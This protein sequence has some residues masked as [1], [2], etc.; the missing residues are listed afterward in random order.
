MKVPKDSDLT[1]KS[2][3]RNIRALDSQPHT[4]VL[5]FVFLVFF[6]GGVLLGGEH[7]ANDLAIVPLFACVFWG[8]FFPASSK[9]ST[10]RAG[11]LLPRLAQ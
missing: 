5:D 3:G 1:E 8:S 6:G 9:K 11:G 10:P 4:I 2:A 7:L